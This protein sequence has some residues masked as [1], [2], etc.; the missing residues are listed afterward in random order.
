MKVA[1][2]GEMVDSLMME[3][4]DDCNS[5]RGERLLSMGPANAGPADAAERKSKTEKKI[6]EIDI[7][8]Y[9]TPCSL[10]DEN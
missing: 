3:C 9:H 7:K 1:T 8:Q 5:P 10:D 2:E 4:C 6:A